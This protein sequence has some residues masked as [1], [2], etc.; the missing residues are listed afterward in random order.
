MKELKLTADTENIKNITYTTML[1]ILKTEDSIGII[2][3]EYIKDELEENKLAILKT[4]FEFEPMEFG[5]YINTE[6]KFKEL[7]DLIKIMKK[8]FLQV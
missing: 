3:K 8:E 7:K 2:T 5:I 4:D 1:G 6:N